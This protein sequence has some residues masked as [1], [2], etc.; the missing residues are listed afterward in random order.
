MVYYYTILYI[1]LAHLRL[2]LRSTQHKCLDECL[3]GRSSLPL[4]CRLHFVWAVVDLHGLDAGVELVGGSARVF[5]HAQRNGRRW[6]GFRLTHLH[7]SLENL[8]WQQ[9]NKV[10]SSY[11]TTYLNFLC[12]NYAE[13]EVLWIIIDQYKNYN[14][15]SEN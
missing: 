13:S 2:F 3:P 6:T 14:L 5:A 15:E 11:S 10:M 9:L 8:K 1:P 7:R 12:F 4:F